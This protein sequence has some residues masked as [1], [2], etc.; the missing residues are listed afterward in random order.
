MVEDWLLVPRTKDKLYILECVA[1]AEGPAI[2]KS[3][4]CTG[5]NQLTCVADIAEK[6]Q[7]FFGLKDRL[8][9]NYEAIPQ[10]FVRPLTVCKASLFY[11]P[12]LNEPTLWHKLRLWCWNAMLNTISGKENKEIN[13]D[14]KLPFFTV[15]GKSSTRGWFSSFPCWWFPCSGNS[16][17]LPPCAQKEDKEGGR[18]REVTCR[19]HTFERNINK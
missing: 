14:N 1:D 12:K 2:L 16:E 6:S 3:F 13:Y 5:A 4:D 15:I 11:I 8:R 18:T 17:P 19:E 7:C 9:M 10:D